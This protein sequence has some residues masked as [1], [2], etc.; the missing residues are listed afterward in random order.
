MIYNASSMEWFV[1]QTKPNSHNIAERNL[2]RQGFQTFLPLQETTKRATG[3]FVTQLR[4]LFPGYIF[5][6][7]NIRQGSWRAV[8]STYGV[9]RLV[10]VSNQPTRVPLDLMTALM[11]RCDAQGKLLPPKIL[12]PGDPVTLTKGPFT[13]FVGIVESLVP[14]QR[15][16]VMLELLGTQRRVSVLGEDL[17]AL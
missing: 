11:Q 3:E 14:D 8:N 2:A 12:K 10:T 6:A 17:E 15:I 4:P 13:D 5:I 7:L 16:W 1:A 9:S